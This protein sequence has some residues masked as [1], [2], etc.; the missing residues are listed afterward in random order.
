MSHIIKFS[1]SRD[2]LN[3]A[4]NS[5]PQQ[6]I[7][8]SYLTGIFYTERTWMQFTIREHIQELNQKTAM[9]SLI[10]DTWIKILGI[11]KPSI[12]KLYKNWVEEN[13]ICHFWIPPVW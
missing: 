9:L 11:S 6:L 4:L 7:N 10:S 2:L 12:T 1:F 5:V 3:S 8:L 13:T